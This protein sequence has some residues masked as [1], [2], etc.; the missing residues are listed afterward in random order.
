[1]MRAD[2]IFKKRLKRRRKVAGKRTLVLNIK[3]SVQKKVNEIR[4]GTAK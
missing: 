4:Y 3:R 2:R 1:M